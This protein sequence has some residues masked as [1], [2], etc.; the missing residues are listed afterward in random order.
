MKLHNVSRTLGRTAETGGYGAVIFDMDG[1]VTD[2]ARLHATAWKALF[3][4]VLPR[5]GESETDAFD[6]EQDYRLYV[7]GRSREDGIRTFLNHRGIHAPDGGAEDDSGTLS[8]TGMAARKQEIFAQLLK[9]SG[10]VVFP[11]ALALLRRLLGAMVPT[12]LVTASRNS[13]EILAAASI[14]DLFTV[15]VDGTDAL[16]L[17]L[18]GKPDPAMFLEA[19]HRLKIQPSDIVVLEDATAGVKAGVSGGFALVV[20]VERGTGG[21]ALLASGANLTVTD[22][23][24]LS[25][26][27]PLTDATQGSAV[28]VGDHYPWPSEEVKD[29]W[30]LEYNQFDPALEGRREALCTLGNGYWATR[31]S[32][33]GSVADS[34]HYPGTYFAGVYNRAVTELAGRIDETEHMVNAPDWTFLSLQLPGGSTLRPG[35]PETLSH[36]QK[37]DLKHGILTR[38]NRYLDS[39]GRTTWITSRQFQSMDQKHLAVL[40]MTVEAEDW[41]GDVDV[42]SAINGA[43]E[44]RNSP[45]DSQ[46]EGDHLVAVGGSEIGDESVLWESRTKQSGITIAMALRTSL[47]SASGEPITRERELV[48]DDARAGH[49]LNFSLKPGEPVT[50]IKTVAAV[51]SRDPAISTA[52][53][54]ASAKIRGASTSEVLLVEHTRAWDELWDSFGV[55]LGAG[56]SHSQALNLNIFHVLQTVATAD[57]D[58]DAG[59]PARGL[60]GEGYRGHIFWDELFVYPMVT[61]RRPD[62]TRSFLMYRYRR[63]GA[64]RAAARAIGHKGAMFPWQS[65]SDGQEETPSTL[66]N[67]RGQQWMPDNSHLQRHS[68][69]AVAYNVWQYFQA[70]NDWVF[71]ARYGAEILVE[72]SRFFA[73]LAVLDPADGRYC[74]TGVMGPDEFHDG[75][76]G[77][78]GAGLRNNAYTNVLASWVL[79][80]AGE[81]VGVVSAGDGG[82]LRARLLVD[83]QELAEWEKISRRLRVAFHAD[84]VISQFEGYEDLLEFDWGS[85]RAT[86]GDIG[87][88]DL[89]LQAEGDSTNCYKLS[90]QADVL[91]LFYLLSAEELRTVFERLGYPLPPEVVP[92][93]I[94]YYLARTSHGS[95][96]SRLA[97]SWVL[98]RTDREQSWALFTHALQCDIE[99][100][101]GGSTREGVHLGAMAGTSDMV[102]RCYGGVETRDNTLRLHPLLPRELS[103][104][105]F[106]LSFHG[107]SI[108]V[109][110]TQ[111]SLSLH[112]AEG[113]AAPIRVCIEENQKILVAGDSLHFSHKSQKCTIRHSKGSVHS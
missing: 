103:R 53:L 107:Q 93:T 47:R 104:V 96:L 65:G 55:E 69:L 6:T 44:N 98:A 15:L 101:Q 99:D 110:L 63:L 49:L 42:V 112:L 56:Q 27:R 45:A 87:R 108:T 10:V 3:D 54:S 77:Q 1:V 16:E 12:A 46:L 34:A 28:A 30:S 83:G 90:K 13:R 8:V 52:G 59:V 84:G 75:Y 74:I 71:L 79:S 106:Q 68:G 9:D 14:S 41:A 66:F 102:L 57:P 89:I 64:A 82:L 50:I 86:Y 94:R 39:N 85:Y 95:T 2:T 17:A 23:N 109:K 97:H 60:H 24:A 113:L 70:S 81:A 21:S 58:L 80:K 37:I 11:D 92:Q 76:P 72:V 48:L 88:L 33:P 20:G 31:G 5:L 25:L 51:T 26:V 7:D 4:E 43:V 73:D 100:T 22:L 40:E 105:S 91:M 32:I 62:I 35:G 36:H 67:V 61:L 18:P 38:K 19:A 111:D 78:A 29:E